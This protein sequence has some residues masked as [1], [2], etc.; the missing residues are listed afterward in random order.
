M[1]INHAQLTQKVCQCA[2]LARAGS[3]P[4]FESAAPRPPPSPA[5]PGRDR[6]L[7]PI[8]SQ[9]IILPVSGY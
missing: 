9:S 7:S 2:G 1:Q 4:G 6:S 8:P 3:L 5:G